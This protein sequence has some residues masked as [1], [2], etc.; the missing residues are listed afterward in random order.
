MTATITAIEGEEVTL[1]LNH[2]LAGVSLYFDVEVIEVR[3]ATKQELEH[4]H[5]HTPGHHHH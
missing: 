3:E 2:P 1:D 5:V 4:G